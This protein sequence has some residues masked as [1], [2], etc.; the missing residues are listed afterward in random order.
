MR[1][2]PWREGDDLLPLWLAAW[3][4]TM[5]EIDFPARSGWFRA[6]LAQ[7][8]REGAKVICAETDSELAGFVTVHPGS[9]HL[10][11]IAVHPAWF[12]RGVA[13]AL[14]DTAKADS[15]GRLW[16]DVNQSNRRA[17]AFYRR[18]GFS[19]VGDG[20]NPASGL[21]TWRMCWRSDGPK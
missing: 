17:V 4:A 14:L 3:T 7:L 19:A 12:G 8:V 10:D 13:T 5:P 18:A 1:L 2:R 9:G 16:L 11:Q 21:A 20:I 15:P 6:H